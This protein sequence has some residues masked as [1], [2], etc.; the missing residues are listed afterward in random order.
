MSKTVLTLAAVLTVAG[1]RTSMPEPARSPLPAAQVIDAEARRLMQRENVNGLALAV[2]DG[3]E[4]RHVAAYGRRNVERNLPLT[5]DTVMYGASLTKTAFAYMVLQ[6]VDEGRLDLDASVASLLPRPLPEYP[7]YTDLAGDDRWRALTPRIVLN[8]TTGFANFRWLE[9]DRK[10]RFHHDPGARYGYS[11]EGF[12]VLQL[13]L[14]EG[15]GLDVGKEMQ[16]RVFDRF[17]MTNSSMAWRPD[18]AAS[19]ADGYGLDG[20]ME[21]H[22]ERSGASAAGSMDTTI[23]DQA[24]MW[25]GILRGE[26][27]SPASRAEL[28][29]PQVAIASAHQFPT[30]RDWIEPKNAEIGLS[31]GLGVVTFRDS[32]GPAWFKGGHNDWTGNM[33]ICLET[34]QRCLV[35]L[36]ND[37]RAERVYAD[38]ARLILGETRM[39]WRWE[40]GWLEDAPPE[41]PAGAGALAPPGNRYR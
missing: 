4:I 8:H 23:A 16:T 25:A 29:R 38:L 37:V 30:L 7:D 19:L 27:L 15:L 24:R 28:V 34:G 9:D 2:I 40:Y 5:T 10:L 17:G 11:G 39:P 20:A 14:E 22:D 31:A 26:G 3:G 35:M 6:L 13:V 1:C 12:Y 33:A 18:F 41:P 21:P 32:S 36:A